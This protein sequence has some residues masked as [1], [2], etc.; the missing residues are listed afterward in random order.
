MVVGDE[1]SSVVVVEA[2]SELTADVVVTKVDPPEVTV[3]APPLAMAELGLIVEVMVEPP[4]VK[5]LTVA[6]PAVDV[7][8]PP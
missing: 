3:L 8:P 5:V 2:V 6:A 1:P 4:E 7:A